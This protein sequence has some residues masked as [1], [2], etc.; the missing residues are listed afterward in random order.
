LDIPGGP[1][2]ELTAAKG[3]SEVE[4]KHAAPVYFGPV[5]QGG[6]E[7]NWIKTVE[8]KGSFALLRS[9]GPLQPF[10]DKTWKPDDIEAVQ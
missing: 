10:F 7:K 1:A 5:M 4:H 6:K 8:G 9:Y 3:T 2:G